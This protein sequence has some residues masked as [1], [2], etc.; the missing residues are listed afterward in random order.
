MTNTEIRTAQV[1]VLNR[2]LQIDVYLAEPAQ[3][4]T[5]PVIPKYFFG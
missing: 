2:D 4:G 3:K 5:F 1:K